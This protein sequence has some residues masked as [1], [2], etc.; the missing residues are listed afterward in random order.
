MITLVRP[1]KALRPASDKAAGV[2]APPYD[3]L[4]TEEARARAAGKPHSFLHISKPEID[5]PADTDPYAPEVYAKAAETL[6]RMLLHKIL[7]RDTHACYYAYRLVMDGHAQTGVVTAASIADYDS[8]R[9]R[10]HEFTR[11]D[12]EDDRVRQIKA[13][14]AQTGPVLLAYPGSAEVDA[15]LARAAGREAVADV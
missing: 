15:L 14:N 5:L 10:K 13:L 3:V 12:K 11:P 9:I 7:E 8:N 1:F 4:N 6:R 2:A